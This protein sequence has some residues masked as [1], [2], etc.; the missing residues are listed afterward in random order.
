MSEYI[1]HI[2]ILTLYKLEDDVTL[3]RSRVETLIG[4]Y[5]PCPD[6]V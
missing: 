6:F 3:R 2:H 1:I 5:R 4:C